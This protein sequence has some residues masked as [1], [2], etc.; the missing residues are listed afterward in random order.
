VITTHPLSADAFTE[1][2]TGGGDSSVVRQLREAQLSK[3]L[4]L[5]RVVAEGAGSVESA[6]P[7]AV[8][9]RAG[10]QLLARVQQSDPGVVGRLLGLPHI[11]SWAHDCLARLDQRDQPDFG[12]LATVAVAAAV[13]AGVPFALQVPVRGGGVLLP[14]L[15]RLRVPESEGA[16]LS[17]SSDG[18]RLEAGRHVEVACA[19]LVPDDGSGTSA[20]YWQGTPVVRALAGGQAWEVLLE[21]ADWHLDRYTPPMLTTLTE[22]GLRVWRDRIQAAWELL[23]SQHQW[24]A[25]PIAAGVSVIVPLVPRSALNS[26]TSPAA[27]G[28]VATSLPQSTASLAE[29]LVH[30]F[31]HIKL[32]G[33]MDMVPLVQPGEELGYAPWRED[34]RPMGGILQ[35]VYA[36]AAI[37]RFW[38]VQRGLETDPDEVLC[39][40]VHY[41]RWR[42]AVEPV[43]DTLS[44]SGALTPAGGRFVTTLREQGRHLRSTPVSA[45]VAGIAREIALDGWLTWQARHTAVDLVAA[46]AL[47]SAYQRGEPY[48]EQAAP[49]TWIEA[50]TRK[51]DS[52]ARSR[53]LAMRYT[54]PRRYRQLAQA[55]LSSLPL[56]DGLLIGGN[57]EAAK[58]AYCEQLAAEP[59]PADWIG[60]ALA[61]DRL[62]V[63]PGRLALAGR[64]PLLMETYACLAGR[65]TRPDPLALAAWFG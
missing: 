1:L 2:A 5:L 13:R 62:P 26:A 22:G 17:F 37:V 36:F 42:L 24:A 48:P 11:G 7:S 8:A 55:D 41:E 38:D 40:S 9:F 23:V 52:V 51:V 25:G 56:A 21:T 60:L 46:A 30:E 45:E 63:L 35:G 58:A 27:F 19:D 16:W 4:M 53:L 3:H 32:C 44:T 39:A 31:Q 61:V 15:G 43:I 54:E 29:T 59:D 47:A 50:E 10:Y 57:V 28:A 12:Y 18:E 20:P 14:G 34:P 33:L 64:L 6:S 65:R 49:G